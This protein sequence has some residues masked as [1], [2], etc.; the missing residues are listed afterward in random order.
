MTT[1]KKLISTENGV[2]WYEISGTDYGTNYTFENET[3]GVTYDNRILDCDG[4]PSTEG[5]GFTVAVRN[6]LGL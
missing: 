6:V 2:T 3:V 4:L 5:D 1:S